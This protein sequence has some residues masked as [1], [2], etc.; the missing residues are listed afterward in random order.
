MK[1]SVTIAV[2]VYN[3][4][5]Y[6][7]RALRS[8]C[9]QTYTDISIL[10]SNNASTDGSREIIEAFART[11]SRISAYHH[12]IKVEHNFEFLLGLVA[13]PYFMCFGGHDFI[14]EN[15]ILHCDHAGTDGR[16]GMVVGVLLLFSNLWGFQDFPPLWADHA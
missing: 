11:D 3:E 9:D 13:T 8:L 1:P 10:V 4:G 2:P 5:A 6:L 15:F 7:E 12:D 16:P 14:S